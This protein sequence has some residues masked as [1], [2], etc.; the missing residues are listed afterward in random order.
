[1]NSLYRL[2]WKR[3]VASQMSHIDVEIKTVKI[4]MKCSSV[5]ESDES[6]KLDDKYKSLLFSGKHEKILFEGHLKVT[7]NKS[8]TK[9]TKSTEDEVDDEDNDDTENKNE[10]GEGNNDSGKV[11]IKEDKNL[12][13]LF[14]SL[15]KGQEVYCYSESE[16]MT[17]PPNARFTELL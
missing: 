11:K 3:T 9:K 14:D 8:V 2:I 6:T 10:E 12:E 17:K 16:E 5:D 13:K 1:M 4:R 15:K 7:N